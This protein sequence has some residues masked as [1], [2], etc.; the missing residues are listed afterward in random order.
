VLLEQQNYRKLAA[1]LSHFRRSL[2]SFH[3][4]GH[5]PHFFRG[6]KQRH[7]INFCFLIPPCYQSQPNQSSARLLIFKTVPSFHG[8]RL[9]L[10]FFTPSRGRASR[11]VLS[12]S[13]RA[14]AAAACNLKRKGPN[15]ALHARPINLLSRALRKMH[16]KNEASSHAPSYSAKIIQSNQWNQSKCIKSFHCFT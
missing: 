6:F 15:W 7:S 2:P 14:H 13:A 8:D 3:V 11:N 16:A 10:K 5:W 9:N 4:S 12:E 1:N